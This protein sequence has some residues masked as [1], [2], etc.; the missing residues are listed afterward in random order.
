MPSMRSWISPLPSETNAPIPPR[1]TSGSSAT[2]CS[3]DLTATSAKSNS[4]SSSSTEVDGVEHRGALGALLLV[5]EAGVAQRGD[6]LGVGVEHDDVG[7]QLRGGDA[8]DRTRHRRP[9]LWTCRPSVG[10]TWRCARARWP[11]G[12]GQQHARLDL[13]AARE[14]EARRASDASSLA[15]LHG[16]PAEVLLELE[17]QDD[18][19]AGG[20]GRDRSRR[21]SPACRATLCRRADLAVEHE[22]LDGRAR[23]RRRRPRC[24]SSSSRGVTVAVN[25]P[26]APTFAVAATAPPASIDTVLPSGSAARPDSAYGL[27]GAAGL[28]GG[29]RAAGG[30][31]RRRRASSD[32]AGSSRRTCRARRSGG[33]T[34]PLISSRGERSCRRR[35]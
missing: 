30:A 17:L 1:A 33:R 20:G 26:P 9:E 19:R 32:A 35:R 13:A 34:C 14:R 15:Y 3:G 2:W 27:P 23:T 21:S 28:L 22:H 4:P 10:G 29:V 12:G 5:D 16:P 25:V 18:G 11:V 31:R 8:A 24:S 6:V 7:V